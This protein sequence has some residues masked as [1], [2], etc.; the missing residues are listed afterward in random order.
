MPSWRKSKDTKE[1]G[2]ETNMQ[3]ITQHND[4]D[5]DTKVQVDAGVKGNHN[6]LR[7]KNYYKTSAQ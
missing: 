2:T 1:Q 6:P 7:V 3:R 5:A 4:Q